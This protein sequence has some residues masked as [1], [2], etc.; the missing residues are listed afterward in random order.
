MVSMGMPCRLFWVIIH[1]THYCSMHICTSIGESLGIEAATARAR[2]RNGLKNVP[3]SLVAEVESTGL[4]RT[5]LTQGTVFDSRSSF[6]LIR[7]LSIHV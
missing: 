6:K 4:N 5:H 2:M 1:I 3:S 7:K